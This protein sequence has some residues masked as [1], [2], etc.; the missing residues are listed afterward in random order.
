MADSAAFYVKR[1]LKQGKILVKVVQNVTW[2]MKP[3]VITAKPK[4]KARKSQKMRRSKFKNILGRQ[5]NLRGGGPPLRQEKFEFREPYVEA[6]C[7]YTWS[8]K[9]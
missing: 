8:R 3:I 4:Q 7:G 6:Y 5:P 1:R 9:S 2:F